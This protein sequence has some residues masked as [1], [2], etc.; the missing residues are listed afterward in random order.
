MP[1]LVVNAFLGTVL[2]TTYSEVNSLLNTHASTLSPTAVAALSGSC[3][4]SVQALAAAPAENV[5]ILLEGGQT[6]SSWSTAWREVFAG[7]ESLSTKSSDPAKHRDEVRRV[8]AWVKDAREMAG[9][10]WHGLG[11]GMAKDSCG[12]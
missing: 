7:A 12:K 3:A 4:G 8:Q 1:P 6:R 2:W 11:F 9:R 5:R 10:G